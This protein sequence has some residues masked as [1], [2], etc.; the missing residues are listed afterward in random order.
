[1]L[2]PFETEDKGELLH[3]IKNILIFRK[4]IWDILN[5]SSDVLLQN[6]TDNLFYKQQMLKSRSVG[7]MELSESL[8]QL[9]YVCGI[10]NDN[11]YIDK[12]ED[13]KEIIKRYFE[14]VVNSMI[15]FM[16]AQLLGGKG[17]DYVEPYPPEISFGDF[18]KKN[19][20]A[21]KALATVWEL[22]IC[23]DEEHKEDWHIRPIEGKNKMLPSQK[24]LLIMLL[25]VFQNIW[26]HC[27]IGSQKNEC[28]V[29]IEGG[30]LYIKNPIPSDRRQYIEGMI[31]PEAYRVTNG[32]SLAVIFDICRAYYPRTR[33]S[34]I[35]C[36]SGNKSKEIQHENSG[37]DLEFVVKLPIFT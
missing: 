35:F 15:G 20:F 12:S 32:I 24:V 4:K 26:K 5:L 19:D 22:T 25:A 37:K 14:L 11:A 23:L 18:W 34:D 10:I 33:F 36:V 17:A 28:N 7:H 6:L 13:N 30:C 29:Y 16:N 9:E 2:F 3:A 8:S 21:I 31:K 1:M 27:A